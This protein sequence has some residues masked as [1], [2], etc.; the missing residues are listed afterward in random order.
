MPPDQAS[1]QTGIFEFAY[2]DRH[3]E[4]LGDQIDPAR[5]QIKFERDAGIV[6]CELA[7][8]RRKVKGSEIDRERNPEDTA[9]LVK[10]RAELFVREPSLV[11]DPLA[12]F[13]IELT[14]LGELYLA[15]R[16]VKEPQTDRLLQF[17]DTSRQGGVWHSE[18]L[19]S[20]PKASGSGDLHE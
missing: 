8:D 15:C 17:A 9:G 1:D 6:Q 10:H 14:G 13:I 3:I 19:R 18:S 12:S 2:A 4:W 16:A 20:L 5:G 7:D 11:D